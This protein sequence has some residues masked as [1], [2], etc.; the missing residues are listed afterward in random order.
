MSTNSES[1]LQTRRARRRETPSRG[2]RREQAILDAA[3][4]LL[5][6]HRPSDLT[7]GKVAGLVG[8]SRSAVYFYFGSIEELLVALVERGL[9]ELAASIES[10]EIPADATPREVLAIGMT[11]SVNGWRNHPALFQTTLELAP[12]VPAVFEQWR[13]FLDRNIDLY[14]A[15]MEWAAQLA[16]HPALS[17][18]DARRHAELCLLMVGQAFH[19]LHIAGYNPAAEERLEQDLLIVI[20]RALELG[21]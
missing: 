2:D 4:Q 7:V 9:A 15:L 21:E 1:E 19:Q 3:E 10:V 6:D 12:H 18:Q 8:I 20:S 17:E 14:V 16:A 11:P 5:Q 13:A